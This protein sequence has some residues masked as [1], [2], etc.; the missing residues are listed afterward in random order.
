MTR[1][2]VLGVLAAVALVTTTASADQKADGKAKPAAKASTKAPAK[3]GKDAKQ[4]AADDA[5]AAAVPADDLDGAGG[6]G[7]PAEQLP[8]HITGPKTVD[9]GNDA[10]IDLPEGMILFE[11]PVAK[12]LVES[13]GG[14][15]DHV[16]AAIAR[17][18]QSWGVIVEYDGIGYVDDSD[19]KDLDAGELLKS[20]Q[21]GTA[22]QNTRRKQLG[23]PELFIDGWSEMPRYEAG[24]HH[25]VWGLKAHD[26]TGPVI[27]FFTRVLGRNGYLSIN[28][29]DAPDAIEKSKV[30]A[31]AV[32]TSTTF[33]AGARYTDHKSGDKDSGIGLK[34]LVLGGAGIAVVK[35]AKAGLIIKLLLVFKKGFILVI[36]GIAAFFRKIFGRKKKM[37]LD[38]DGTPP[39]DPPSAPPPQDPPATPPGQV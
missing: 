28:L 16:V 18:G 20:Y 36:A 35:A 12:K 6:S 10:Q 15:G 34:A 4:P 25:L 27:N 26:T 17:P 2:G 19:A 13:G 30:D 3:A 29:I 8:E 9:L 39:M 23:V 5:N 32:L 14:T 33:K 22:E 11:A 7:A 24:V 21:E 1:T 38:I 37:S 31:M